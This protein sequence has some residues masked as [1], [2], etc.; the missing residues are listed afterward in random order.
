M[1]VEL[2]L[3]PLSFSLLTVE[4]FWSLAESVGALVRDRAVGNSSSQ[5]LPGII[6]QAVTK[7]RRKPDTLDCYPTKRLR[8]VFCKEI[9]PGRA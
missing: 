8:K 4:P 9:S 3:K 1:G 5:P 6:S 7:G 2:L